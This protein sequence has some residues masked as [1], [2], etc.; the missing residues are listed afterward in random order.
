[1]S[2]W[3]G[4]LTTTL[5]LTSTFQD[6][7]TIQTRLYNFLFTPWRIRRDVEHHKIRSLDV[8]RV[9]YDFK[10]RLTLSP[11][12][13]TETNGVRRCSKETACCNRHDIN[14]SSSDPGSTLA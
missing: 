7:R 9:E 12:E 10:L 6:L 2:R 11:L 14:A 1:M 13:T 8:V 5:L 3:A 4:T